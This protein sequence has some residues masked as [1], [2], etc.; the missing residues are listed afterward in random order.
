MKREKGLIKRF[1][2]IP[3]WTLGDEGK[4]V[5][6]LRQCTRE[7]KVEPIEMFVRNKLGYA[8]RQRVKKKVRSLIGISKDEAQR[9]K[10]SRTK[11]TTNEFP[12]CDM[13]ISRQGCINL[14]REFCLPIPKKSACVQCPYRSDAEWLEMKEIF[15]DDFE[16][17]CIYDELLRDQRKSGLNRPAYVHRS[18][19]PLREVNFVPKNGKT[20]LVTLWDSFTDE[21]EGMCGV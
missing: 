17:A 18:L 11:W 3:L 19:I 10:P 16:Q 14:L 15:P 7:Y 8:P 21:C 5:P 6:I 20:P 12:L 9:M 4:A 13:M 1:A 2:S